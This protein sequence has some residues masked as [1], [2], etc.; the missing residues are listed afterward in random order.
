MKTKTLATPR[1]LRKSRT[2]IRGLDEIT[3]GGLP[4]GRPTLV[5]GGAGCGKTLL[6]MEFLVRGARDYDEPGVFM[7]FE[8]T[9]EELA[10]NVASLG[11]D[12]KDLVAHKKLLLDYVH[13]D[14]SEFEETGEYDLE[15][16]FIRLGYAIDS[17]KAKR[18]VLDTIE[19]L[20]GSLPN[21]AIVRME[22][23]RLF[24]WLKEKGVTVIMTGERGDGTLTRYGLEE[25]VSDCVISL[26]HRVAD[27][28]TTRRIRV[29]KYR[30]TT[31][32][33]NEYPF[34]IE[35]DGISIWPITSVQVER[36]VSV[37]RIPTGIERL[38]TML[39]GKGFYR[40]SSILLSGTAGTGKTS[41]AS[42]FAEAACRR[43]EKCLFVSFEEAPGQIIR[44]MMT[45]GIDL[46]QWVKKDRLQFQNVRAFQFGLEMHLARTIK[47]ISEFAP[48]VV[49]IDPISGL[50]T[51]GTSLEVKAA[52]MRL[53]DY[54][55]EK[56]ITAMLTDLKMGGALE[57]TDAAIS[58]LV[59]TWLVL[60]DLESNGE[61]NRGLHVLKSRGMGHSNQVREFVLS[62]TGIQ[63]TD[64]YI[65]PSG[66]LTGSARVAQEARERAE[67]VS[68]N[69]EAERQQLALECKRAALEGQIAALRAEFSAEEAT[70]ARIFS[71]DKQREASLAL[72]KVEMG[73]SR[74][75]D[76]VKS[77]AIR[78]RRNGNGIKQL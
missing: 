14:R 44:N 29:V 24:R 20:F 15:G 21:Q 50:E 46:Q 67:H 63:L 10:D 57:R 48:D 61:R 59:D 74:Q 1:T 7:A 45:I 4:A 69:E 56:G 12:L 35:K 51:S 33:T 71:Q 17:I 11:F 2:G 53:V 42:T 70:I 64:V 65:G 26:D 18:V 52:L 40:G 39:G 66:M 27:Q 41:V 37:E 8:E 58:S 76:A 30:G 13:V 5:C 78:A 23:R 31:H 16:L 36:S 77:N 55:K 9:G 22:L 28:V 6:A 43:G 72:D 62:Q 54:L 49:I 19:G 60:R 75:H 25:Y 68:L 3:G 73:R 47:F 38:D 34:L 32:G